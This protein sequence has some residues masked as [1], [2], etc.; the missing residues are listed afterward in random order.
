MRDIHLEPHHEEEGKGDEVKDLELSSQKRKRP[1]TP[2]T[3]KKRL[4][5]EAKEEDPE[6][7][8]EPDQP[9]PEPAVQSDFKAM[10]PPETRARRTLPSRNVEKD[11]TEDKT[12]FS[13]VDIKDKAK[14]V[15]PRKDEE[16]HSS[17][18][19]LQPYVLLPILSLEESQLNEEVSLH[20]TIQSRTRSKLMKNTELL[21]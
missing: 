2:M 1:I 3:P 18:K 11:S 13:L 15:K 10:V 17:S 14:P 20:P 4:C 12:K 16:S 5:S 6:K 21:I 9:D 8:P 19:H 7:V